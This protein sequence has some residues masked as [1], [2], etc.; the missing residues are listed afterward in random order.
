M[1]RPTMMLLCALGAVAQTTY[2]YTYTNCGVEHTISAAPNKSVTM[3]QGMTEFMLAMGLQDHMAATAYLDDSIWPRYA[4]EYNAIPVLAS[5]YPTDTQLMDVNVDF[6]L[7]NY[8]SAVRADARANGQREARGR[9]ED[10]SSSGARAR[11]RR[12]TESRDGGEG[13]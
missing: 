7:A 8:N 13:D 4:T 1:M 5:G 10:G 3:N 6:I 9:V 11:A 12:E 2:P